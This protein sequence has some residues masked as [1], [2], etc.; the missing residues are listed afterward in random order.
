MSFKDQLDGELKKRGLIEDEPE[1]S[2]TI[3]QQKDIKFSFKS[4]LTAIFLGSILLG[5][6]AGWAQFRSEQT[7]AE[8]VKKLPSKTAIIENM[9]GETYRMGQST[10]R[11]TMPEVPSTNTPAENEVETNLPETMVAEDNAITDFI[12]QNENAEKEVQNKINAPHRIFKKDFLDGSKPNLSFVVT[13]LGL[14]KNR[15]E[16]L[17]QSLPEN[18]TL[19]LS[20]YSE[21]LEEL[22][23][24]ARENGHEVWMMMPVQTADYP[25]VDSGPLTFLSDASIEQNTDRAE[26]LI[27]MAGG[28]V[29]FIPQK[30]HSFKIEDG[31]INPAIQK[32]LKTGFAIVDSNTSGDSFVS[33]TSY[34]ADY[35]HAQN[36]FWLDDNLTPLAMN[37]K[38]RQMIKLAEAKGHVVV[39]LRPYPTS[40]NALNK[41]LNS[42]AAEQF[43]LAPASAAL[44]NAG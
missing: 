29:G 5:A 30:N 16:E 37:Q 31:N 19:A 3:D 18:V 1:L 17:I 38:I 8:L 43:E 27:S 42:G 20:P 9:S 14:S 22:T 10:K 40:I 13:D 7:Q 11:L 12:Q 28:H 4:F 23:T 41:F 32:I 21:Y 15:T 39:M 2:K 34:R 24:S 44:K 25:L 36:N 6:L 35:P 33:D 26:T